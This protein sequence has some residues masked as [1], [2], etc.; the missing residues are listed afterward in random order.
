MLEKQAVLVT[1]PSPQTLNYIN[2]EYFKVTLH[3]YFLKFIFILSILDN[4]LQFATD[5]WSRVS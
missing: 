2:V 1:E 5:I 3:Q 4:R